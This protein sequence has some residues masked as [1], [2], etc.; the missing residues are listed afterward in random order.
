MF[1]CLHLVH[2]NGLGRRCKLLQGYLQTLVVGQPL[3]SLRGWRPAAA[4][5]SHSNAPA[6]PDKATRV[7]QSRDR[8]AEAALLSKSRACLPGQTIGPEHGRRL[9]RQMSTSAPAGSESALALPAV[10]A[11]LATMQARHTELCSELSSAPH[12]VPLHTPYWLALCCLVSRCE[13]ATEWSCPKAVH[14]AACVLSCA[15]V[16]ASAKAL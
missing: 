6:L 5:A 15:F 2:N 11:R 8:V 10:Q 14:S 16:P 13:A 3:T 7:E 12:A 4:A 1:F 9:A